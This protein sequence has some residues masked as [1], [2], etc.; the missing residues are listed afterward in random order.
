MAGN[1]E[2][3]IIPQRTNNLSEQFY[4][5]IKHL[6]RRLTGKPTVGKDIDYLP[7]EIVLVENLKNQHYVENIVGG[8]NTLAKKFAQLD[9][10]N[11]NM[12]LHNNDLQIKVPLKIIRK[13]KDFQPM[14]KLKAL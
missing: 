8:L 5:K 9:I 2:K 11:V 6:L 14:E 10:Q 13:L 7:E 3:T 1:E 4:R 12:Y